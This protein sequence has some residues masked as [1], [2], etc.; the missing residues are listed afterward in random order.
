MANSIGDDRS[1]INDNK[2]PVI[3][4]G[5][6][7]S[8]QTPTTVDLSVICARRWRAYTFDLQMVGPRQAMGNPDVNYSNN[9]TNAASNNSR[10]IQIRWPLISFSVTITDERRQWLVNNL[11]SG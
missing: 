4:S 10:N 11:G 1:L 5:P 8:N 3:D 6:T 9:A 7:K 2:A